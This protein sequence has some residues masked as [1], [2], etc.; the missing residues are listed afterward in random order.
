[1]TVTVGNAKVAVAGAVGDNVRV[2]VDSTVGVS[3]FVA[4]N[5]SV[6]MGVSVAGAVVGEIDVSV[7]VI[8]CPGEGAQAA[9]I[10]RLSNIVFNLI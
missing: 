7:C 3:V 4:V 10:S 2:A 1:L 5:V 8:C 6:G 9:A